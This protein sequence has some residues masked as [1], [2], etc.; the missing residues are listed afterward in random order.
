MICKFC[1][2]MDCFN[3]S[4]TECWESMLAASLPVAQVLG[5]LA[6]NRTQQETA[7]KRSERK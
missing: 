2:K 5:M 4:K 3:G 1:K 7:R 6:D